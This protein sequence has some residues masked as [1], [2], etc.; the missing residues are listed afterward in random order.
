VKLKSVAL[1]G[2][3]RFRDSFE[4]D[5][6]QNQVTLIAGE[7]GAGKTSI[8]DAIC[9]SLYG[10]TFRT[11]GRT[12]S[13]YLKINDLVNHESAKA[14]IRTEFENHGHNYVVMREIT[15][16]DSNGEL[17]ED[18]ES[19]ATGQRVYDYMR[20]RA[21]GLDW[22]GF[23]KS[24]I[25]LQDEMSALTELD[26]GKR[27]DAFFKLFGLNKYQDYNKLAQDK[28]Q[29]KELAIEKIKEVNKILTADVQKMPEVRRE[30]RRLKRV[31]ASLERKKL[32]LDKIMKDRKTNKDALEGDYNRY[33]AL[34]EK[35][36][37][38]INQ[39]S[40]TA[41]TAREKSRE[42]NRL[43]KLQKEFPI[44][45]KSYGEYSSLETRISE[46]KPIKSKFDRHNSEISNQRTAVSHTRTRLL[47]NLEDIEREREEISDLRKQIPPLAELSLA[48]KSLKKAQNRKSLL[49]RREAALGAEIRQIMK[50]ISDLRN[51]MEQVK[52]KNKCPICLRRIT[53]PAQ[54]MKHYTDE[55]NKLDS[56]KIANEKALKAVSLELGTVSKQV[57]GLETTKGE[58]E[59][60]L[61]KKDD[62]IREK[63]RLSGLRKRKT[64]LRAEI[65]NLKAGIKKL[66]EEQKKL[67]FNP[68]EYDRLEKRAVIY[69][70]NKVA[71]RFTNAKTEL[72]RLPTV[73][74][75]LTESQRR[76]EGLRTERTSLILEA[77]RFGRIEARYSKAK[78]HFELAQSA[79]NENNIS[80]TSELS[81]KTQNEGR[82]TE[83]KKKE[84]DLKS[85]TKKIQLL[86][87]ES[88]TLEELRNIFKSIPENILRRLRP[89]IE[90]EGTDIINDLSN[91]EITALNIEENTLNVAATIN[92]E[93]KPIHYFSGGQKTRI[94]MALR[95]A[96]SRI[97]S[98]LPQ[99]E[100]HTFAIMQTLF[101]D[102]GDFG[103]LDEAGI[104]EAINVIRNLTKEFDRVVL[105][106][107]VDTIREIFHGYTI[108][109]LKKDTNESTIKT[110]GG[111]GLHIGG[112]EIVA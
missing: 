70:K 86:N 50:S 100:E 6:P 67:G 101:I 51:G 109:V 45:E 68:K 78:A 58:L 94:N 47:E 85:N 43:L 7:N 72:D 112:P 61:A 99:T 36:R 93:V 25:V 33:V 35:L 66:Q 19:K 27:R 42:F 38:I 17:F 41:K 54:V 18:G 13:G 9:I 90:K 81:K 108:E 73:N 57:K 92:G 102:E 52:G 10:K 76:L 12:T 63:S 59:K 22:E 32:K 74:R 111:K 75:E 20:S 53:D 1:K 2:F 106:S 46:L 15:K 26:P 77:K 40:G 8:L 82:L 84:A 5:F 104:R 87:D 98:K 95:V 103:N 64:T 96:I 69:R 4:V 21:I 62:L 65:N 34:R 71:E 79:F 24:T 80:L 39:I 37:G 91:S 88:L 31:I 11:S 29:V 60:R 3:M 110:F 107:H 16:S 48:R 97:L 56:Q 83:L 28:A 105:I 89:F 44:L 14:T 49:D 23:R 55:I 30:I